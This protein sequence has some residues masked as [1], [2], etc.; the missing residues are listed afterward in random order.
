MNCI[1]FNNMFY[2]EV[3]Y[4][5]YINNPKM[6]KEILNN[7]TNDY[8]KKE[9]ELFYNFDNTFTCFIKNDDNNYTKYL[10]RLIIRKKDNKIKFT[11]M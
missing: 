4:D 5:Q 2:P 3:D 7:F 8:F 6:L 1:K 11:I 10:H 9:T